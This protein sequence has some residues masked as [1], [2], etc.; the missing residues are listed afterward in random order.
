MIGV[1]AGKLNVFKQ[2]TAI[3][4]TWCMQQICRLIAERDD[5]KFKQYL[6]AKGYSSLEEALGIS[7]YASKCKVLMVVPDKTLVYI[8]LQYFGEVLRCINVEEWKG[9]DHYN[10][11]KEP[12]IVQLMTHFDLHG[13]F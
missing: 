9:F 5:P 8:Y 1:E 11:Q 12:K 13:I 4:K 7:P 10:T 6:R 3:G 2:D